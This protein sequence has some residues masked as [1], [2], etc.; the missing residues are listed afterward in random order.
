MRRP[1][2]HRCPRGRRTAFTLI[3]VIGAMA[4]VAIL[5]AIIVPTTVRTIDRAAVRAE[6]ETLRALGEHLRLHLRHTGSLPTAATWNTDLAPYADR[7]PAQLLTTARQGN[8]VL[9]LDPAA[10]P[11]PRAMFLSS[12]RAGLTVP[13]AAAINTAL[14]FE[15][16]W[17]TPAGQVPSIASWSGWS[18][19]HAV[20]GAGDYLVIERVP[21]RSIHL[22]D[23][24]TVA[25]ALNNRDAVAVT[26]RV[27]P[28]Q[29]P[30][31][32]PQTLPA[33]A[34]VVLAALR[35]RDR[36]D[37]HRPGQAAPD[38]SYTV[39]LQAPPTFE[40]EGGRWIAR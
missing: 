26:Y 5:A 8:R 33:G 11:A 14:R 38:Y 30:T 34:S 32:A 36:V 29:G 31:H 27:V 35:P 21:L 16:I 28:A 3:E 7:S 2:P 15:D 6:A 4:I 39:N 40:F 19:W 25:V 20:A 17:Q 23:L 24:Q 22:T 9:L 10:S 1:L 18:Q 12:M 13:S 37:L